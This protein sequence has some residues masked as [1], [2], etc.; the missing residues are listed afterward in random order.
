MSLKITCFL[1]VF[2]E[3][4]VWCGEQSDAL[5]VCHKPN[6]VVPTKIENLNIYPY[7]SL[8]SW[9]FFFFSYRNLPV[10]TVVRNVSWPFSIMDISGGAMV[11]YRWLFLRSSIISWFLGSIIWSAI[12][13]GGIRGSATWGGGGALSTREPFDIWYEIV[14]PRGN[15]SSYSGSE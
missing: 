10:G 15:D 6:W 13:R 11:R 4:N 3:L 8:N 7:L 5:L 12:I 9:Y 14:W 2:S 1:A